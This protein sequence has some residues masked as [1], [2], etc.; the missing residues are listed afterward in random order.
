M[1][2]NGIEE[3]PNPISLPTQWCSGVAF[4]MVQ[5]GWWLW[6]LQCWNFPGVSSSSC[7]GA[8][9]ICTSN[10]AGAN[11]C[12]M[13]TDQACEGGW[14]WKAPPPLTPTP[15]QAR[16]T[17]HLCGKA[18]ASPLGH[19]QLALVQRA[20]WLLCCSLCWWNAHFIS[21]SH[22]WDWVRGHFFL[23][24]VQPRAF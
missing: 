5:P 6:C 20:W 23:E 11:H 3:Q 21:A 17:N 7:Y 13:K 24:E 22:R 19:W 18:L 8:T 14:I 2:T 4:H 16:S 1:R 15:F 12:S 9:E 10:I